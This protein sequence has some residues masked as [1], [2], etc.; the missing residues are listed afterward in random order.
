MTSVV[1]EALP[2][3]GALGEGVQAAARWLSEARRVVVMTGAGI[4]AGCGVPTF[5]EDSGV[6]QR[7]DPAR[8]GSWRGLREVAAHAPQ[9]AAAFFRAVLEPIAQARPGVAHR[10]IA[11]MRGHIGGPGGLSVVTQNIDGLHQ[12]AG[13]AEVRQIHGSVFEVVSHDGRWVKV[14]RRGDLARLTRRLAR[15]EAYQGPG[16]SAALVWAM[17]PLL[18]WRADHRLRVIMWGEP[19]RE[20]DWQMALEEASEADVMLIIGTSGMVQPAASLPELVRARGGHVI[21]VDPEAVGY[22][23]DVWLKAS[24]DQAMAR[25]M[26]ALGIDWRA[27]SDDGK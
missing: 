6:W 25:L 20:P 10:A 4:S 22:E 21:G 27:E 26:L 15:V 19:L 16:A 5:R 3:A 1:T 2:G 8:F 24:A 18:G 7:F 12:D 23:V 9:Q 11:A 17:S 13:S 14:L